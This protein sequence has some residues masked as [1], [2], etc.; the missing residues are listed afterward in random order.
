MIVVCRRQTMHELHTAQNLLNLTLKKAKENKAKKI[1]KI[2]I[3][4]NKKDHITPGNLLYH[5]NLLT[6][7][8]I[9]QDTKIE[10]KKAEKTYIEN[11]EIEN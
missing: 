8:T 11:I 9:A 10:I 7:D 1:I 3:S 6:K 4:L 5:L 2:N